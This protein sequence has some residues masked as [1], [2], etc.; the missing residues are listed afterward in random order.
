MFGKP[1]SFSRYALLL[2]ALTLA[3]YVSFA[4]LSYQ[5][6]RNAREQLQASDVAAA[7]AELRNTVVK[8]IED[9]Q[10]GVRELAQWDELYQQLSSR[11]YFVYWYAHRISGPDGLDKRFSD[12]MVYDAQG[13][14]LSVFDG[15]HLP[16][17]VQVGV[18]SERFESVGDDVRITMIWP[19]RRAPEDPVQGYLGVQAMLGPAIQRLH[20]FNLVDA[21]SLAFDTR[22]DLR[23]IDSLV[24][25]ATYSLLPTR[26]FMLLDSLVREVIVTMA[27]LVLLPSLML[28]V[29]FTRFV[30]RAVRRVPALVELL[31]E[32][33]GLSARSLEKRLQMRARSL[34]I[35]ELHTAEQSLIAYHNELSSANLTLD[36]KNQELWTMAHRDALTGAQNRRAFDDYWQTMRKL[37]ERSHQSLRLMLCDI[38]HFKA[39][40]DSYG[41]QTGDAV[42]AGVAQ[43]LHRALRKNE[44]LYRLGGDEFACVLLD[45]DDAQAVAVAGRCEEEVRRYPF[46][47]ELNL[48]EPV[49]LSIGVSQA[50]TDVDVSVKD[51]LR[52]AD[53]AMYA[54]K[55]PGSQSLTIYEPRMDSDTGGIFSTSANEAVYRATELRIGL[56]MHYQPITSIGSR[57]VTYY[58]GLV[59]LEHGGRLIGPDEIFP[60]V[61]S[62][63][64]EL[65]LD[66]AVIAQVISDVEAGMI[67]PGTGVSINLS[68]TSV[69]DTRVLDW[70]QPLTRY[71]ERMKIV[72][73]VTETTL[74]TR[75][76]AA[77]ENLAAMRRMGLL[78][79]LD[80]FGSGYSSLRYL[81][82]MPV[83]IVKFDICLVHALGIPAQRRMVSYLVALIAEA[84]QQLVAEGIETQEMLEQVREVGFNCAQGFLL[85]RPMPLP[86]Q[87]GHDAGKSAESSA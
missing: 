33:A 48:N 76:E 24:G 40:N 30:G 62:R 28:V 25:A 42:L 67:P 79:A 11:T 41:H 8:A 59:R 43:C 58:E 55:R 34:Q 73:E 54:S 70:L 1:V 27:L 39:I 65:D 2:G 78:I 6:Y 61:E 15:S 82:S 75:M 44:S 3:I 64:L 83:D 23:D 87:A 66:Q 31:R 45:C 26:H 81:T 14:A 38:N 85:G 52:Q 60:V 9:L 77:T 22:R 51:L 37:S 69:V 86:A 80:D 13:K 29:F 16:A 50:S 18:A 47:G 5:Q 84:G 68:A 72:I 46:A 35:S 10:A 19:L 32:N 4:V 56:R 71:V 74:I 57:Q 53:I 7:Q 17:S 49:R 63:H 20:A 21:S 36:Q 12:L